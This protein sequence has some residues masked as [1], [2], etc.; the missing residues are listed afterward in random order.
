METKRLKV[1]TFTFDDQYE[2]SE[3][4]T[5]EKSM[6]EI[7]RKLETLLQRQLRHR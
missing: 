3:N 4:Y 7:F 5:G 2:R 6:S 1:E